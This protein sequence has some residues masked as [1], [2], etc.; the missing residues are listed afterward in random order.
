MLDYDSEF[1]KL[2]E[3]SGWYSGVLHHSDATV[4]LQCQKDGTIRATVNVPTHGLSGTLVAKDLTDINKILYDEISFD[5]DKELLHNLINYIEV[6]YR[7]VVVGILRKFQRNEKTY[8]GGSI[9]EYQ[10]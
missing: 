8:V 10:Q 7:R 1:I 5:E 6:L 3:L 4:E 9:F 2:S